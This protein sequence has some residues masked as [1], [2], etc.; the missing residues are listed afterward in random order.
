MRSEG[1]LLRE[2]ARGRF[3]EEPVAVERAL[4]GLILLPGRS[5]PAF[6]TLLALAR[7]AEAAPR[8]RALALRYVA[9]SPAGVA[10]L[11]ELVR[12]AE[13][14]G[15]VMARTAAARDRCCAQKPTR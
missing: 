3:A 7:D 1:L 11:S 12:L 5:G 8:T 10:L 4:A 14:P 2:L 13:T 15:D 9:E 6:P